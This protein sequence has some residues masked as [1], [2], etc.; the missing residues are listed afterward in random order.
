MSLSTNLIEHWNLD[1]NSNGSIIPANGSDTSMSYVS[2]K[3]GSGARFSGSGFVTVSSSAFEITTGLFTISYWIKTTA[4]TRQ[5][6]VSKCNGPGVGY[7]SDLL[8]T[9]VIRFGCIG[10]LF[11]DF[12][13][14]DTSVAVNDGNWHF[15]VLSR[16][17]TN[18]V[19]DVYVDGILRNGT[20]NSGGTVNNITVGASMLWGKSN[21]TGTNNFVGD[22][23][24]IDFWT[25]ALSSTEIT[26]LYNGGSGLT[27]PYTPNSSNFFSF[28]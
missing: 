13:V 17:G 11:S 26:Q 2:G 8:A 22:L 27:Y 16:I 5:G 19:P 18:S 12:R 15:I 28:M 4:S 7:F 9:G 25:R 6:L 21:L 23:D 3:I 14:R 1:G 10:P 20:I 24:H